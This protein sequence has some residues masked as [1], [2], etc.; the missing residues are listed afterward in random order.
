MIIGFGHDITSVERLE[1]ALIRRGDALARR[2]MTPKEVSLWELRNRS[3][4]FLAGRF[5]AK[6]ALV[7]A[8][9]DS[10]GLSFQEAEVLPDEFG[11]PQ[12]TLRGNSLR[13]AQA[14][15]MRAL[16]L[17]I[18]HDGGLASANLLIES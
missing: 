12:M 7:K 17:S 3:S 1:K 18:S 10:S 16:W 11:A 13:R 2:I 14:L 15:G 8:L 9:R 4:Q 6:E 5:A